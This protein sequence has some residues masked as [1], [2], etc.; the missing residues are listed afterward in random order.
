MR[1]ARGSAAM[2]LLEMVIAIALVLSGCGN[3]D[4][5]LP[6]PYRDLVV[7]EA[8][9]A[10]AE[11]RAQGRKLFLTN[12]AICHGTQA[13][14]HGIRT[15]GLDPRPTDFT[16]SGWRIQATPRHTF[17]VIRDGV[18]GTAMASWN[19]FSDEDTWKL[20][21]YTLSVAEPQ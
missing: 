19:T 16:S 7:P 21:A 14:G 18:P 8:T 10:S 5:G 13:D 15:A 17:Y 12:C 2:T 1:S 3:K 11:A 6:R 9:L 20:V 4:S